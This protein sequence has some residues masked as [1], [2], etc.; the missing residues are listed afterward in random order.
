MTKHAKKKDKKLP[1]SN[2]DVLSTVMWCKAPAIQIGY[3][4]NNDATVQQSSIGVVG[5]TEEVLHTN[6][7]QLK[8]LIVLCVL[9]K[10]SVLLEFNTAESHML[11]SAPANKWSVVLL[12]M[13]FCQI[14]FFQLKN[15]LTKVDPHVSVPINSVKTLASTQVGLHRRTKE[16]GWILFRS[17]LPI[18]LV[19]F[20]SHQRFSGAL[21][22]I[23]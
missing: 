21:L 17:S 16:E 11:R 9:V 2:C 7:V 10:T 5:L 18:T 13:Y 23:C 20:D 8:I 15:P 4:N 12:F 1:S 22:N 19:P 6:Y 3:C 14:R